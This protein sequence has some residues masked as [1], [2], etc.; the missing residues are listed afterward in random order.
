MSVPMLNKVSVFARCFIA[1]INTLSRRRGGWPDSETV[2]KDFRGI[3]E[4]PSD[5][6]LIRKMFIYMRLMHDVAERYRFNLA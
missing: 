4:L 3:K 6:G 1:I 5:P 2:C